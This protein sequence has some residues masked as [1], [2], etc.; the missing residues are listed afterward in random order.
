LLTGV[1]YCAVMMGIYRDES[2][3]MIGS[4][5]RKLSPED[6]HSRHGKLMKAFNS[7]F[8][9]EMHKG[10]ALG[11]DENGGNA[12]T[13]L[14]KHMEILQTFDRARTE[15]YVRRYFH[16]AM[17]VLIAA[18]V[19]IVFALLTS[20]Q[21]MG[22]KYTAKRVGAGANFAG[23]LFGLFVLV[24]CAVLARKDYYIPDAVTLDVDVTFRTSEHIPNVTAAVNVFTTTLNEHPER[25]FGE[26]Y[27]V[28]QAPPPPPPAPNSQN[29]R[30]RLLQAPAPNETSPSPPQ[31]FPPPPSPPPPP[32][33]AMEVPEGAMWVQEVYPPKD[34]D[35]GTLLSFTLSFS[36]VNVSDTES[37]KDINA[38]LTE[39]VEE[40]IIN[41]GNHMESLDVEGKDFDDAPVDL[42]TPD[43]VVVKNLRLGADHAIGGRWA[44]AILAGAGAVVI[45]TS[46][47]G[48]IGVTQGSQVGL[49]I[50][51]FMCV[52]TFI[53]ITAATGL[54]VTH[55]DDTKKFILSHWRNI[56]TGVI[57]ENIEAAD[58]S[59]FANQHMRAAAA[60]GA[61]LITILIVAWIASALSLLAV[62]QAE[63]RRQQARYRAFQQNNQTG[64]RFTKM[65]DW[66]D[67]WD[68]DGSDWDEENGGW[69]NG[70]WEEDWDE[71]EGGGGDDD[72]GNGIG[73]KET[74]RLVEGG[75][76]RKR[77]SKKSRKAAAR[78]DAASGRSATHSRSASGA[79]GAGAG[80]GGGALEMTD[81]A[82]LV[83]EAR[84]HRG[85]FKHRG[86]KDSRS[87]S[88]TSYS[89]ESSPQR[90]ARLAA[91]RNTPGGKVSAAAKVGKKI[92]KVSEEKVMKLLNGLLGGGNGGGNGGGGGGTAVLRDEIARPSYTREEI[93]AAVGMLREAAAKRNPDDPEAALRAAL[94]VAGEGDAGLIREALGG[95]GGG[96]RVSRPREDATFTLE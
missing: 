39:S 81:L 32:P 91:Q 7:T 15:R 57:G 56:Q 70:D 52:V 87:P 18:A 10:V 35:G 4:Y 88:P 76:G 43:D 16:K 84:T 46:V 19:F 2:D 8:H 53:F 23:V 92:A 6:L 5:W 47:A 37:G 65:Q 93:G 36:G 17:G 45:L 26:Y 33:P 71:E 74:A 13:L 21:V 94:E 90:K 3:E 28:Q 25:I 22:L 62:F 14:T 89:R 20:A 27:F 49:I 79:G 34:A 63:A 40:R 83:N 69:G 31:P 85:R 80:G 61:I 9:N 29:G 54:V 30:R 51:I 55:S 72:W 95:G 73:N 41:A 59:G 50:H 12:T 42:I 11:G 96:F 66:D 77:A 67:D 1:V 60:L 68:D 38:T 82:Q 24:L 86:G 64:G 58:A 75:G 78:R 44:A 48:F